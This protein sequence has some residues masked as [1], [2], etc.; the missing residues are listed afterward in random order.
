MSL[1]GLRPRLIVAFLLVSAFGAL[2]TS[3]LTFDRARDAIL[4]RTREAATD[5]LRAQLDSRAP[6]LP[7]PPSTENL[8]ELTI[9]LDRAGSPRNWRTH[10][11]YQDGPLIPARPPGD[12]GAVTAALRSAVLRANGAVS[13]RVARADGP[14]LVIGMPIVHAGQGGG[15]TRIVVYAEMSLSGEQA[16][17]HALVTAA[18]Y[19]AIPAVGLAIVPALFAAAQVLR[20]VRRLRAG[21]RRITEGGLDTRIP[22]CGTDELADLTATFNTMADTIERDQTELR[23]LEAD[24]RRF[25]A[26]VSHE[27]RTPLAAMVAVTEVLDEDTTHLDP[28]VS[29]ALGLVAEETRKLARMVDDL[30]EISRFDAGAAALHTDEVDVAASVRRTLRAR[31]WTDR[32]DTELP[33]GIR[34]VLDPRRFDV[35]LA[36]LVGNALRHGGSPVR[37]VL[38]RAGDLVVLDVV[39]HG[40]GLDPAV[41]PHIFDRFYKADS[42][43]PR[44]QGSGLGLA[45]ARENIH[46]HG[47]TLR[48]A[49]A[50]GAGAVFTIELPLAPPAAAPRPGRVGDIGAHRTDHRGE[51]RPRRR[52]RRTP[53]RPPWRVRA[54]GSGRTRTPGGR[55]KIRTVVVAALVALAAAVP[56]AGCGIPSTAPHGAGPPAAGVPQP[57]TAAHRARL[58]F[59]TP[60]GIRPVTRPADRT[61][62]PDQAIALLLEGP[63]EAERRQGLTT[64][65]P[66]LA[67]RVGVDTGDGQVTFTLPVNVAKLPTESISQL[68]CTA[69][70]ALVPGGRPAT[71]VDIYFLE[72]ASTRPWGPLHCTA[73]GYAL[74]ETNRSRS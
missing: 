27:L 66:D 6:D 74:P 67:G 22:V 62:D 3:A 53:R 63:T 38:C 29:E 50:A 5:E 10:V 42:A 55:M 57:G 40:P 73:A 20:P 15:P 28:D 43:R 16:D 70:N 21:A 14:W 72:P 2:I 24:A 7:Y 45:I 34:V 17:I 26:D 12:P 11:S 68:A 47:G 9:L 61:V 36:N 18:R 71:E 35:A 59:L 33:D 32:V 51:P 52:H 23:R 8:L 25:A 31:G 69:A 37:V 56:A 39:D 46:L 13:Q 49:N 1:R 19:G 60:F 44:S 54:I 48:A 64:A 30:M 65:L 4:D 41:L 58:F